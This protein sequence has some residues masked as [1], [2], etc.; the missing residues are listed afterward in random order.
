MT[1]ITVQFEA[2]LKISDRRD[3]CNSIHTYSKYDVL[4]LRAMGL[5][6]VHTPHAVTCITMPTQTL[7]LQVLIPQ[8][9]ATYV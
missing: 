7:H 2:D 6:T 1:T 4:W 5:L 3:S 8:G 9:Q